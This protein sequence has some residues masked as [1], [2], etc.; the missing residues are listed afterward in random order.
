MT[1]A[2]HVNNDFALSEANLEVARSKTKVP[3]GWLG[4]QGV[5]FD[6]RDRDSQLVQLMLLSFFL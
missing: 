3:D 5:W 1:S 2:G 4:H 6:M